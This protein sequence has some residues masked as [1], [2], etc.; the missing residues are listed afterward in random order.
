MQLK[1]L[2]VFQEVDKNFSGVE[3]IFKL[4]GIIAIFVN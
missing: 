2:Q 4:C 3:E 1:A